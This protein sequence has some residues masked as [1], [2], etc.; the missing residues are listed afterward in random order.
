MHWAPLSHP[1]LTLTRVGLAMPPGSGRFPPIC[2]LH[3]QQVGAL[4]LTIKHHLCVDGARLRINAEEAVV[5]AAV[6]QQGIGDLGGG[7]AW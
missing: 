7:A 1:R 2:G 4:G 3:L 5:S 6:L